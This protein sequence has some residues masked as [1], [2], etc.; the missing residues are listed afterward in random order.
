MTAHSNNCSTKTLTTALLLILLFWKGLSQTIATSSISSE[1]DPSDTTSAAAAATA[2][3][4]AKLRD[5]CNANKDKPGFRKGVNFE[6]LDVTPSGDR[7]W[8][9]WVKTNARTILDETPRSRY[10][11]PKE[12]ADAFPDL[13]GGKVEVERFRDH[14]ELLE[15]LQTDGYVSNL[16]RIHKMDEFKTK[17]EAVEQATGREVADADFYIARPGAGSYGWHFNSVDNLVYCVNGT[18]RFRVAGTEVGSELT[19]DVVMEPG[20]A[21]WVPSGFYHIGVGGDEPSII[22]SIGFENDYWESTYGESYLDKK[23]DFDKDMSMEMMEAQKSHLT[24]EEIGSLRY[25]IKS[26]L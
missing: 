3:A 21:V 12:N 9:Q 11:T 16:V 4:T 7:D 10:G 5:L 26:E 22:F 8:F 1:Q 15:T 20:D 23:R 2:T 6:A 18:K 17:L 14:E 24:W 13:F 25:G 19:V